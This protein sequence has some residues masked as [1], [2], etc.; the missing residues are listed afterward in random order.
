MRLLQLITL[1]VEKDV[2]NH[3]MDTIEFLDT[4]VCINKP[5]WQ[6]SGGIIIFLCKYY[7]VI[8]NTPV[9]SFLDVLLKL[10]AGILSEVH[11]KPRKKDYVTE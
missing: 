11:E 3:I 5:H 2:E 10:F 6:S 1:S 8:S 9:A 4:H 7:I